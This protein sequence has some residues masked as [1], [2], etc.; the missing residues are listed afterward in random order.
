M[1]AYLTNAGSILRELLWPAMVRIAAMHTRSEVVVVMV[2]CG[3]PFWM[4][5]SLSVGRSDELIT[6]QNGS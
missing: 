1:L 5:Q 2:D 3:Y 4:V 6:V